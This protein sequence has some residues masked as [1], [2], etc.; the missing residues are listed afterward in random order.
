MGDGGFSFSVFHLVCGNSSIGGRSPWRMVRAPRVGSVCRT[1]E[2][3]RAVEVPRIEGSSLPLEH[4]RFPF[5][6][7]HHARGPGEVD[8]LAVKLKK[9]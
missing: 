9:S 3:E 8:E 2:A 5:F 1:R 4:F 6:D 7:A